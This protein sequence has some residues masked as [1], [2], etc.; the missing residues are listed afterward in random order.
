H[1]HA[2]VLARSAHSIYSSRAERDAFRRT[3]DQNGY[4]NNYE[5]C[6]VRRDRSTRTVRES[7]FATRDSRGK[8]ISYSGF[9][10]DVTDQKHAE[11]ELRRRN[12]ELHVLNTIA[13]ITSR[14]FNLDD[15][16]G[17]CLRHLTELHNADH[18]A[19]CIYD[20]ERKVMALRASYGTAAEVR[21]NG[22]LGQ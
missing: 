13:G 20:P 17:T 12:H 21:G 18:A 2:E 4:V 22:E 9:L 1:S 6:I 3:I 15:I 16:L 14:S 10:L 11:E 5:V 8:V 7:S 19:A